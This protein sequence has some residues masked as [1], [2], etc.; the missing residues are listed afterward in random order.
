MVWYS[1]WEFWI[2]IG[3]AFAIWML[4]YYI[5]IYFMKLLF[6]YQHWAFGLNNKAYQFGENLRKKYDGKLG[7]GHDKTEGAEMYSLRKRKAV[8]RNHKKKK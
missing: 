4:S 6:W 2:G 1:S 8:E 5:R 3:I 7:T